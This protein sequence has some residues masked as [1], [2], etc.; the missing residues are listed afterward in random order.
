MSDFVSR[1]A[2]GCRSRY[3]RKMRSIDPGDYQDVARPVAAMAKDFAAGAVVS[4]HRHKRAQLVFAASGVMAVTTAGGV[5][6]VPPNRGLWI[7][8]GI[9]HSVR[10]ST[11]VAMRTLYIRA[12]A[13]AALPRSVS[14]IA[15][16]P[17]LR[18]LILAATQLPILYD[19][20]GREGR[21]IALVLDEIRSLPVLPLALPMPRERRLALLCVA[22]RAAPGE[23]WTI[24]RAAREAGM[25]ERNL[26]RLFL[27]ETGL[28]FAAWLRQTRLLDAL[29][30]LARGDPITTVALDC[31]YDSPSAFASMFRK[32]FGVPPS[33]YFAGNTVAG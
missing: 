5:W 24:A 29:E 30:R 13:A 20:A 25:S 12:D 15:V 17:L 3:A 1:A 4:P 14:V 18:E 8:A 22:M 23:R 9:E 28:T 2:R 6:V 11:A 7:P 27:G 21:I 33:Q 26:G 16:A 19:E 31:G 10:A 32:H